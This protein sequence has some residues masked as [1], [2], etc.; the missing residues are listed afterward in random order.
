MFNLNEFYGECATGKK[1]DCT[2]VLEYIKSF[3][4][5][6][7]RGAAAQGCAIGKK[8]IEMGIKIS[9]YWDQR[10][11][12]LVSVNGV[13]VE[14]P[15]ETKF[16]ADKTIIL[17]CIPNHVIM[18][19]LIR[20]M[21]NEG[22]NNIIRGDILYSALICP[23]QMGDQLSAKRCW[24]NGGECRSVVCQKANSIIKNYSVDE[25]EDDRID[26]TYCCFIINSICNLSC[27]DCV[28][29]MPNYPANA[30]NNVPTEII[31]RDIDIFFDMVDSVGTVS[32]MGGET[33]MHP[34]VAKIAQKFSEKKN[35]GF[36]SFPT[37]GLFPI[38]PEQLEGID[39]PRIIIAFG[40]YLHRATEEQ[41]E[42]YYKNIELV[43]K[44]NI[45]YTESLL[46]PSWIETCTLQKR[47]VDEEYM[48]TLKQSCNLPSRNLQVKNGKVHTCDKG[49][50]IY[51]MGIA[52]YPTDYLDLTKEVSRKER[53][54]MFREF[55]NRKF[56]YNCSHCERVSASVESAIQGKKD[57]F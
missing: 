5:V 29:Y 35:L 1:V 20:E 27:R 8:L 4:Y 26:L 41:K 14:K 34:D 22:Y 30:R 6:V 52:D 45:A 55:D 48:T 9:V 13:K 17:H 42:I 11:E 39:D 36:V 44:Y 37:N 12:E 57:I 56:Y 53:R 25:K 21:R 2:Q 54:Q 18:M 23:Y 24:Q 10:A 49:V 51:N 15:F 38:K 50:A 33:F 19:R 16:P 7:L 3:E 47:D 46:L 40:Y 31:C 28:Q 43:K 32:V